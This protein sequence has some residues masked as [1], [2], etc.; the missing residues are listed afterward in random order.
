LEAIAEGLSAIE[1]GDEPPCAEGTEADLDFPEFGDPFQE[2]FVEEEVV[3]DPYSAGVEIFAD[4]PRVSSWEGRQLSSLLDEATAPQPWT[5]REARPNVKINEPAGED[6]A[7]QPGFVPASDPVLPEEPAAAPPPV[8]QSAAEP[9][10]H[11]E[12]KPQAQPRPLE[13]LSGV[14]NDS[15][16]IV[17]E[18]DAR[19]GVSGAKA[20]ER[21]AEFRQLFARLRRG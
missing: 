7:L 1:A 10:A 14:A 9:A 18:E 8:A 21:K 19:A 17:V 2:R 15:D 6:A 4:V 16:V 3:I 20:P 12:P 11:D 5:P 13:Q